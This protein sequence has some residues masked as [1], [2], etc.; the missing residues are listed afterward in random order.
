MTIK[1]Y[2]C[3]TTINFYRLAKIKSQNDLSTDISNSVD[4][5]N[6]QFS[7]YCK[8]DDKFYMSMNDHQ[9]SIFDMWFTLYFEKDKLN[10]LK[11]KEPDL[12]NLLEDQI[13]ERVR[14]E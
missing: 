5:I 6:E 1:K 14:N 12:Y 10:L 13:T 7:K 11:I 2:T 4:T 9:Q 3:I 8:I